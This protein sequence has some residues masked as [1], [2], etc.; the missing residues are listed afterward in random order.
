ML[1]KSN[2]AGLEQCEKQW[3]LTGKK[4]K[5]EGREGGTPRV[6][7]SAI[8]FWLEGI[9]G[10]YSIHTKNKDPAAPSR[11]IYQDGDFSEELHLMQ[12]KDSLP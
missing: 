8:Q 6:G 5:G 2:Q 4:H 10:V 3:L 12:D 11:M 7:G 9:W 1:K